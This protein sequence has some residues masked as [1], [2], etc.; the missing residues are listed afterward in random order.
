MLTVVADDG[1]PCSASMKSPALFPL[2]SFSCYSA[3]FMNQ[4]SAL[5]GGK[6][7]KIKCSTYTTLVDVDIGTINFKMLEI[8]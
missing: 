2:Y 1:R 8:F 6:G 7:K 5:M 3:L 4:E